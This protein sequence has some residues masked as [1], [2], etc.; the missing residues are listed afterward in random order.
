[1]SEYV[2]HKKEMVVSNFGVSQT[3]TRMCI[4]YTCHGLGQFHN[5]GFLLEGVPLR[6]WNKTPLRVLKEVSN[7][8][9]TEFLSL[10]RSG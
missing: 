4:T 6:S 10:G 3:H 2:T 7:H 9:D 8:Q 5:V 1:M